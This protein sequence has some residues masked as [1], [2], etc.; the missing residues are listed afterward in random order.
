MKLTRK[1]IELIKEHT[2]QELKGRQDFRIV[3]DF[4]RYQPSNANWSYKA[5]Y[6]NYNGLMLLVVTRFGEIQ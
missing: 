5:G 1:Q 6:I 3:V 4:G 2:P